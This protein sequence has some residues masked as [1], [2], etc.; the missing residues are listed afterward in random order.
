MRSISTSVMRAGK[1][2]CPIIQSIGII[3]IYTDENYMNYSIV[4]VALTSHPGSV[5]PSS[6][7]KC[8]SLVL[9]G[10]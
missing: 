1:L 8:L 3:N 4:L 7:N 10:V 2:S 9:W 5:L 6:V